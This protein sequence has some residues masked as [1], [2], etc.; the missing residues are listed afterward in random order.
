METQQELDYN[1][2][3]AAIQFFKEHYKLQP[4][5]EDV[6]A[7]VHLSPFHFQRMFRNWAGVTPKQFLQYLTA[8]YAK[9]M[10]RS[11]R[12][13]LFDVA[14]ETG[15]SG[16]GRLHDLLVKVEGMTPGEYKNGGGSLHINYSFADSPFGK[17]LVA[18]T[19]KGICHMAFVDKGEQQ[20]LDVLKAGLPN[21]RYVQVVDLIQQ[22]ALFVFSQD[23]SR[24][25]EVKLHLK[26]TRFQ[27]KVW[28]TLL[29]VPSG[30]FT[31]Y[32]DLAANAGYPGASRAVGTAVGNNPV[33]ML[34]PCHR[35]I[36]STG[37]I[38]GY[39]WGAI[40]K[41]AIIGWEASLKNTREQPRSPAH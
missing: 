20:A 9:D 19:S 29:K 16:T 8:E 11:T 25:E 32:G 12:A 2:I 15:L 23:W 41:N 33:A 39:H 1:R 10:L 22:Q 28:E 27:I 26:G 36:R 35:V 34:I 31:T 14:F 6:A 17:I 30:G 4:T 40:R 38:G 21:A 37:E 3:A 5:L 13:S 18:S 7:H 24:L